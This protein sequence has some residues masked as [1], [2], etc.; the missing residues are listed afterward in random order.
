MTDGVCPT[1]GGSSQKMTCRAKLE[2]QRP[3]GELLE[4]TVFEEDLT[5]LFGS[6]E[7]AIVR[8]ILSWCP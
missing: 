4:T 3:T 5:L 7:L 8:A 1:C 6:L 2:L